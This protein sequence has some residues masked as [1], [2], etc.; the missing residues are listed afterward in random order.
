M[1]LMLILILKEPINDDLS[2]KHSSSKWAEHNRFVADPPVHS[3]H[4][5]HKFINSTYVSLI[6][7]SLRLSS[8][9]LEQNP[10]QI[11]DNTCYLVK[12]EKNTKKVLTLPR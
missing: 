11:L 12:M 4:V 6:C 1:I 7:A 10:V 5:L 3:F 2:S 8:V 9:C